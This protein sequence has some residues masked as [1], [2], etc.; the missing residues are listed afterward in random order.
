MVRRFEV[1]LEMLQL[2]KRLLYWRAQSSFARTTAGIACLGACYLLSATPVL[3]QSGT[4]TGAGRAGGASGSARGSSTAAAVKD[5]TPVRSEEEAGLVLMQAL[6]AEDRSQYA[7]AANAY[8]R[9]ILYTLS[10]A[11]PDGDRLS[12]S[13]LGLER[14]SAE[15]GALDSIVPVVEQIVFRRPTDPIA[16]MVYLRT[17]TTLMREDDTRVA[18][19]R[20]R[21]AVPDDASPYRE[22]AKL[23]MARG[24]ALAADT[25]LQEAVRLMGRTASLSAELAQLHV[26]ME[27]WSAAALAYRDAIV[28]QPWLETAALYG[29]QRAPA[30]ARD[31]VRDALNQGKATLA[32]ARLLSSLELG[33]GE[34][35]RAWTAL[36]KLP[37]DDSTFAA[38][39]EF[40]EQTENGRAWTVSRDAWTALYEQN[41][42]LNSQRHA[43]ETALR[44]GDALGALN[45]AR[46]P[47]K[48]DRQAV[49]K[50]MAP[51]EIAALGMLGRMNEAQKLYDQQI[52]SLNANAGVLLQRPLVMGWLAVGD[53]EKARQIIS[54]GELA[55]DD[56]LI[57][58]V[59]LYDGDLKLARKHL[60]RAASS[61]T[62]GNS[63]LVDA[64]GLLARIRID[65]SPTLGK[66]FLAIARH[67][68]A[69][70]SRLFLQL[71]D[72][73]GTAAP[74]L[75]ALSA[76]LSSSLTAQQLRLKIVNQY[77]TS[78]EAPEALLELARTARAA[79]DKAAAV[80]YLE[81]LL[82]DYQG[83]ALAPQARRELE[84]LRGQIPPAQLGPAIHSECNS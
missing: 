69:S 39:R 16:N 37:P 20:W 60:L 46:L 76:R 73:V 3:S 38:W 66:A 82:I 32:A 57:G 30:S 83:S 4:G 64:L 51:T 75:I 21:R 18:Y 24:R 42:D 56:E 19:L 45:L 25:V 49:A 23:L 77:A 27:R 40:A 29:L 34:P 7:A 72:S 15:S 78:P 6:E 28:T 26:S 43:A 61:N 58:W 65:Q 63:N 17:L 22:Y 48:S 74:A 41:G 52:G 70:A 2:L 5:T 68:S 47:S 10:T 31:S 81:K 54:N 84:Q 44:S 36:A 8:K 53:L 71:V 9:V 62:S 33:W 67:D 14:V 11:R 59:A 50:A 79:G 55:N 35:R 13:M 80:S 1:A 12:M